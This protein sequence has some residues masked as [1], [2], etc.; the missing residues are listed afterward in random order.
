MTPSG[1]TRRWFPRSKPGLAM[2]PTV[3]TV[4]CSLG[5]TM[6]SLRPGLVA[7]VTGEGGGAGAAG[8]QE[9]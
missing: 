6:A 1:D 2:D 3:T 8:L 5:P 7:M 9:S 4:R